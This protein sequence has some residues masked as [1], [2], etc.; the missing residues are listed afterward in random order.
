MESQSAASF[1]MEAQDVAF[2]EQS[3]RRE[4]REVR[5]L[6]SLWGGQA[7]WESSTYET[8]R[9]CQYLGKEACVATYAFSWPE[10][11]H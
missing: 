5:A 7:A 1:D 2:P 6:S 11:M 9:D 10:K 3:Q 4:E 8:K